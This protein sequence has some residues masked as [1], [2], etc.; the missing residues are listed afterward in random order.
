LTIEQVELRRIRLPLVSPFRTSSTGIDS[1]DVLLVRVITAEAVGWG[2]CAAMNE[3]L[4]SPEYTEG[5]HAVLREHLVP[6]LLRRPDLGASEVGPCLAPV[7]GHPMAKSAVETAVLDAELRTAGMSLAVYLG[8]TTEEV[9]VGVSVGLARSVGELITAVDGYVAEGYQRVKLKI[10]PGWDVGPVAAVRKQFPD[11]PLQVDANGAYTLAD[12]SRLADLDEF[13]L[14]L[15]EQPLAA[16]DLTAHAELA[17]RL[18]TP[19]CLDESITSARA[20]RHAIELGATAI[21]N[22]KPG[23]VGGYLEARRVHDVCREHGVPAWCGGMLETGIGRA[24]NLAL[25]ALP[26]F[27]LPGDLSASRRYFARDITPPFDL[28]PGGFLAVPMGPGIGVQV[29][30]GVINEV[31]TAVEEFRPQ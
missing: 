23:R 4:Y 19:I 20:A 17:R 14:V 24:A 12:S 30:E 15:I 7:K 21:I 11:L 31:T 13:N 16:D 22:V 6:R 28:L 8:A 5:A 9:P 3:P 27:N 25:A 2:E 10:E 1:R 29:S 26:G 18:R